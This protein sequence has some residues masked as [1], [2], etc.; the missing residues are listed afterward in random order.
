VVADVRQ[1]A[2]VQVQQGLGRVASSIVGDVK[3]QSAS[4]E[5]LV[6]MVVARLCELG[7]VSFGEPDPTD[8]KG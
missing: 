5:Y 8:A 6:D 3:P 2:V 7:R 1:P 4:E